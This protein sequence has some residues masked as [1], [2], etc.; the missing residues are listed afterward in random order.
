MCNSLCNYIYFSVHVFLSSFEKDEGVWLDHGLVCVWEGGGGV[1]YHA[2][3][4]LKSLS[5]VGINI[6]AHF[7]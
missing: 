1:K 7:R 3:C 2:C 4:M 6:V 5:F